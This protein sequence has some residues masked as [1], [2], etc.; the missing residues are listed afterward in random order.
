[1]V[2]LKRERGEG[3]KGSVCVC[4]CVRERERG[5]VMTIGKDFKMTLFQKRGMALFPPRLQIESDKMSE[6]K[7]IKKR[8]LNR[9][10]ENILLNDSIKMVLFEFLFIYFSKSR[11]KFLDQ[12]FVVE[13]PKSSQN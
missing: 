1:M 5:Y 7:E 11:S 12:G 3:E 4:V 2:T 8:N 6:V 13:V 10:S 9:R